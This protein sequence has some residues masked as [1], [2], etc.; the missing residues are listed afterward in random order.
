MF[1]NSQKLIVKTVREMNIQPKLGGVVK[2]LSRVFS[3][4]LSRVLSRVWS[5]VLPRVLSR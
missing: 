5:R 4:V 3:R 1:S 2:L